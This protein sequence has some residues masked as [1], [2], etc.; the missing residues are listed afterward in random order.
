MLFVCW[1]IV[2]KYVLFWLSIR[3][4]NIDFLSDI[5]MCIF[6]FLGDGIGFEIVVVFIDVFL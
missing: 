1:L 5:I 4:L 2:G 3:F 6:V